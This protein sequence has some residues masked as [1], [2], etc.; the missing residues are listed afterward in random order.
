MQHAAM[1]FALGLSNQEVAEACEVTPG[2]IASLL[3]NAW[4][5]QRIRE[6]LTTKGK[7]LMALVEAEAINSFVV[8]CQIRDDEKVSPTV[9]SANA[10]SILEWKLGKPTQRVEMA[11][12]VS[13]ND[14]VAEAEMLEQKANRLREQL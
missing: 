14:P 1:Y 3:K 8:L 10:K 6:H 12:V 9:R 11:P 2:C 13:S 4:F 5:A 7:D